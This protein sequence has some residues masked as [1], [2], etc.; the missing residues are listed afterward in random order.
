MTKNIA[1]A[2]KTTCQGPVQAALE[3]HQ[4]ITTVQALALFD[5]LAPVDLYFMRGRW[6]GAEVATGHPRA[7]LLAATGWYGKL[8]LDVEQVHPLLF[9]TRNG[10]GLYAVDPKFLP[11]DRTLLLFKHLAPWARWLLPLLKT[12]RTKAR[13]RMMEHRGVV[14]ATMVYDEKPIH[15]IFR[16]L[17]ENRVFAVMD[18]KGE[19]HPYFF[20]LQ[21]DDTSVYTT[22][23]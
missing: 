22:S 4:P 1:T 21:R 7:G 10:H 6:K 11:V 2:S 19:T 18:L 13:L 16:R 12:R 23:W 14:S 5:S 3:A 20:T 8:F 15:D 17:D 9:Y